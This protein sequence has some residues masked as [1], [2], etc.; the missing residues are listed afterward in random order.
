MALVS[1]INSNWQAVTGKNLTRQSALTSRL[2]EAVICFAIGMCCYPACAAGYAV[3]LSACGRIT[4]LISVEVD[5]HSD[6]ACNV[7]GYHTE[8]RFAACCAAATGT[9][10]ILA[11]FNEAAKRCGPMV[12]IPACASDVVCSTHRIHV[13]G[14]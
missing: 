6:G 7:D 11:G 9:L 3:D 8:Y 12:E 10:H 1:T 13:T 5:N 14:F 2:K 4:T